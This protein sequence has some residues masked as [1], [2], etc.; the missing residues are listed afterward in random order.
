[1]RVKDLDFGR[2]E[3]TF[4]GGKGQK[5]RTEAG[6]H[7]IAEKKLPPARAERYALPEERGRLTMMRSPRYFFAMFGNPKPPGKDT[8]E[9]GIYHPDPKYAPFRTNPGDVLLLY[10]AGTYREYP[11][12]AP[13]LGVVLQTDHQSVQYRYLLFSVPILKKGIE[14]EFDPSDADKFR[15]RRFAGFWLFQ[16]SRESFTRAVGD[17]GIKWP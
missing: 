8:V 6:G 7:L 10:C 9:S 5:A 11:M 17:R 14:Q 15:N 1:M 4:R 3:I 16:I 2:G 13:G 12:R